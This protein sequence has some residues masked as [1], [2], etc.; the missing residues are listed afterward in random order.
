MPVTSLHT[1][2]AQL[3]MTIIS[4]FVQTP[5]RVW[6]LWSN[7]RLLEKWWGP[8]TYPATVVEHEL[9]PGGR[10]WYYMSGPNGERVDGWWTVVSVDEPT[11]LEFRDGFA[12]ESG[13]AKS[14]MPVTST[15]VKIE[16]QSEELTRMTIDTVFA[17]LEQMEQIMAMG[18]EEGM[19]AAMSQIDGLFV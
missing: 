1:D 19:S 16:A 8:P 6:E 10:V 15:I 4:E 13:E 18:M 2:R 3:T 11:R 7:P 9:D 5:E 17:S 12:D 14:D